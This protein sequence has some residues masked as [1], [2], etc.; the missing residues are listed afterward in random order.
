MTA[1]LR[2]DAGGAT[3]ELVLL[4]PV[5]IVMLLFI[6]LAGRMATARGRVVS[7]SRDAARAASI[8]RSPSAA[9]AAAEASA[10]AAL[11]D[12]HVSCQSMEVRTDVTEFSPGGEVAVTV[13]CSISLAD[14]SLLALPGDRTFEATSVEVIDV[15]T[16]RSSG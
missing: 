9:R 5:L 3:T 8:E 1:R 12:K 6:V 13:R 10:Q 16:S 4:T 7:A 15:Y 2:G 11:A 14:L